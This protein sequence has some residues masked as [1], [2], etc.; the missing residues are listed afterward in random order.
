[1]KIEIKLQV[2]A[3]HLAN[4]LCSGFEGGIRYWGRIANYSK[5]PCSEPACEMMHVYHQ[6]FVLDGW[7]KVRDNE[8][9]G[10]SKLT[11]D[12]IQRA[13]QVIADKYP[14]HLGAVLG[15]QAMQDAETGDVLIQCALFGEVRYG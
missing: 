2:D 3:D 9:G 10:T 1:M 7:I 8:A 12:K 5:L 13:I 4:V 15:N 6:P 11:L 14:R